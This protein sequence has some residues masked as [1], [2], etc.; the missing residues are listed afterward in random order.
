MSPLQIYAH[1][2]AWTL[3]WLIGVDMSVRHKKAGE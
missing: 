2:W 3:A 1:L